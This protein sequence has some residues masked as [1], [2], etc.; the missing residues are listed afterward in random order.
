MLIIMWKRF[1]IFKNVRKLPK[2]HTCSLQSLNICISFHTA[3]IQT[4]VNLFPD[5]LQRICCYS[6]QGSHNSIL[7]LLQIPGQ[8]WHVDRVFYIAPQEEIAGCQVWGPGCPPE[9]W[10]FIGPMALWSRHIRL[11]RCL[12]A[13]N[14]KHIRMQMA[15]K[16]WG[17]FIYFELY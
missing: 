5:S 1:N 15:D 4:I 6:S 13:V 8:W 3:H 17:V 10:F 9:Q 16:T 2:F 11:Q 14:K 12:A 7:Q